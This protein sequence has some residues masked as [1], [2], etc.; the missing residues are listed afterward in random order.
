[1]SAQRIVTVATRK[2]ALA[3]AQCRSWMATLREACGVQ[4]EELHVTTT[5]DRIQDRP[6]NEVGGKGL[7]IKEIEEALL[8]GRADLAL[9]SLKDVPAALAPGLQIACIAPREDA[10]DAIKTR[11][12][13]SLMELPQGA[14]VGTSS[15]RR[16]VQLKLVRPDLDFVPLRGNIDTRLRRC[17]EGVVDAVVLAHAGLRRLGLADQVTELLP[18]ELCLPAVGQG[19]LAVEIRSDDEGTRS[20]VEEVDDL[21]TALATA[22]ERGVLLAVDGNCQVPVAA[23]AVREGEQMWLRALLAEPDGSRLRKNEQR[24]AWPKTL[25]GAQHLGAELGRELLA[26]H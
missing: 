4:T 12:G 15:L 23:Y 26:N 10:R 5:G 11:S 17:D 2:S 20:L 24:C 13:C 25:Q 6:L 3:L 19:A 16:I 9:H 8:A 1:M 7:F 22:A 21:E 18:A 14:R